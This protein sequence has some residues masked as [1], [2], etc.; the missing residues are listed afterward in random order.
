MS[1]ILRE[2][3]S[4]ASRTEWCNMPRYSAFA[5]CVCDVYVCMGTL[6]LVQKE[7]IIITIIIFIIIIMFVI[8]ENSLNYCTKANSINA[9]SFKTAAGRVTKR[10]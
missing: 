1:A 2:L 5:A 7:I 8:I 4:H 6:W 9:L 3:V 10:K